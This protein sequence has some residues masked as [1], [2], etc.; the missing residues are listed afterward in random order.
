MSTGPTPAAPGATAAVDPQAAIAKHAA[1]TQGGSEADQAIVHKIE[2]QIAN[3]PMGRLQ[4]M[5]GDAGA[6]ASSEKGAVDGKVAEQQ[7]EVAKNQKDAPP[8]AGA[9]PRP[10]PATQPA[11]STKG[12]DTKAGPAPAK[13]TGGGDGRGEHR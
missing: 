1:V 3:S 9:A 8:D 6:K 13:A 4:A 5:L 2:A 11:V 10:G 12:G 7:A